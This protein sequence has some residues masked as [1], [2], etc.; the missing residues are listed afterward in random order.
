MSLVADE[1]VVLDASALVDLVLGV[2]LGAAVRARIDGRVLHAPAHLDAEV[3]SVLGRLHRAGSLT[4]RQVSA[5]LQLVS[6]API[7]RHALP[8][9]VPGAWARRKQLRLVDALYVELAG[10]L[11]APLITTDAALDRATPIAELVTA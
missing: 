3:L 8:G 9:L 11:G 10:R 1:T 4:A 5:Q 6:E 7:E 2:P